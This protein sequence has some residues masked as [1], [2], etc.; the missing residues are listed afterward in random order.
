MDRL[1]VKM[2]RN[3]SCFAK[4]FILE[5]SFR[6][7][8]ASAYVA[9]AIPIIFLNLLILVAT[10]RTKALHNPSKILFGNLAMTDFV[11]GV[12]SLLIAFGNILRYVEKEQLYCLL[13]PYIGPLCYC[14]LVMNLY[15]LALISLDRFLA[16]KL[17]F[18]Y[19]AS[20]TNG[21][22]MYALI[23]GWALCF[24]T[25]ITMT[26]LSASNIIEMKHLGITMGTFLA[27][28]LCCIA[29]FSS[30]SFY[31]LRKLT[32]ETQAMNEQFSSSGSSQF[33]VTKYRRT[34]HTMLIVLCTILSFFI[35][36]LLALA[37]KTVFPEVRAMWYLMVLSEWISIGNSAIN[38]LLYMWRMSDL[39]T[40]V[41]KLLG[42]ST[43]TAPLPPSNQLAGNSART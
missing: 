41:K 43:G 3:F 15:V 25:T 16:V 17:Q 39:R 24:S 8:M 22:V 28:L 20:V 26:A 7:F 31:Q 36:N 12:I 5:S 38:P 29:F 21:R 35:P 37:I 9:I 19:R 23:F 6:L 34:F 32:K 1:K 18:S 42:R 10:W 30:M 2:E 4:K 33:D 14:L 11:V 40:A 13:W 27:F